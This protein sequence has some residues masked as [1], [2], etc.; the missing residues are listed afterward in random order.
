MS[1]SDL[2]LAGP[3][4]TTLAQRARPPWLPAWAEV[5]APRLAHTERVTA[6]LDQWADALALD[7]EER[8]TWR[9]AGRWHDALRDA[10][11]TTLREL[12][13]DRTSPVAILHGPAAAARL[14]ADGEQRQPLLAGIRWHTIGFADWGRVG[15]ALF[16]ADY[17]DPGRRFDREQRAFLA[18]QLP[19]DF[20]G[21]FRQV[22]RNRL[23]WSVREGRTLFPATVELWNRCC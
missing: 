16:M 12:S 20:D 17:L 21:V 5:S 7:A 8:L 15:R 14:A 10:P 4:T 13:G 22:L 23:E 11:E 3:A 1:E 18:R 9:D 2:S 19:H 6:L